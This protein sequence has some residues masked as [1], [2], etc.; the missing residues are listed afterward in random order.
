MLPV[1]NLENVIMKKRYCRYLWKCV[2]IVLASKFSLKNKSEETTQGNRNVWKR[3]HTWL[4]HF[5]CVSC[6]VTFQ[7]KLFI[8]DTSGCQ[9]S[10]TIKD[11][12]SAPSS[13]LPSPAQP[14][15]GQPNLRQVTQTNI[16]NH[17]N[18]MKILSVDVIGN[19]IHVTKYSWGLLERM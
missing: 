3:W 14:G 18:W 5:P 19:I 4:K 13:V 1:G 17:Q 10:K 8:T 16:L 11:N 15:M 9:F 6:M 7:H 2:L 12:C